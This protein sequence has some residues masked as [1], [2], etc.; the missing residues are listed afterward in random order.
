MISY[1]LIEET[2]FHSKLAMAINQSQ[3]NQT[4]QSPPVLNDLAHT[5]SF[6]EASTSSKKITLNTFPLKTEDVTKIDYFLTT[7]LQTPNSTFR[8][9]TIVTNSQI[10]AEISQFCKMNEMRRQ[11]ILNLYK[12]K[13]RQ[14]QKFSVPKPTTTPES[15]RNLIY[16]LQ[17]LERVKQEVNSQKE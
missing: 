12:K 13:L 1:F 5:K 8:I 3:T 17:C 14:K 10:L 6:E 15:Q 9:L 7:L 16:F 2:S 4:A 11:Q